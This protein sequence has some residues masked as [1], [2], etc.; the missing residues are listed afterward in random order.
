MTEEPIHG[1]IPRPRA[2]S[3]HVGGR[4]FTGNFTGLGLLAATGAN[5]H[6]GD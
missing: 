4:K 2:T 1:G 6:N 3:S 5:S